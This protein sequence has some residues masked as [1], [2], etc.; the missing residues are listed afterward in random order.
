MADI[1]LSAKIS[2]SL[3]GLQPLELNDHVDYYIGAQF[4]GG[5]MNWTRSQIGSPWINGLVTTSR[6]K[7]MVTEP[8]QFEVLGDDNE[9][10]NEKMAIISRAFFQSDFT[11]TLQLGNATLQYQCEAA[12][13]TVLWTGPRIITPQGQVTFSVPRQPDPLQGGF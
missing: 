2:R 12:D 9:E 8:C 11:I 4:F 3:L 10:I 13:R 1:E 5:S 7:G 6:V